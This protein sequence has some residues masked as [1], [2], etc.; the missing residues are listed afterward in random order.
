M[1]HCRLLFVGGRANLDKILEACPDSSSESAAEMAIGTDWI[2]DYDWISE[3]EKQ[4]GW[5]TDDF[6]KENKELYQEVIDGQWYECY[7]VRDTENYGSFDCL[8]CPDFEP[9]SKRSSRFEIEER[10]RARTIEAIKKLPD[11]TLFHFADSHW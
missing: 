7:D 1:S 11:D 4:R 10:N 9:Y 3:E 6:T 8:N 5:T 2:A